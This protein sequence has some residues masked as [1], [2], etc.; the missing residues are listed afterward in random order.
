MASRRKN[1][2]GCPDAVQILQHHSLPFN[3]ILFVIT[4]VLQFDGGYIWH[5]Q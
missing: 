3:N 5:G 2:A 4:V 1:R